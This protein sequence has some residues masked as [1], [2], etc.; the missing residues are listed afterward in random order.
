MIEPGNVYVFATTPLDDRE[1]VGAVPPLDV[2]GALPDT[3][4]TPADPLEALVRRP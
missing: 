3:D 2:I 1:M 4:T